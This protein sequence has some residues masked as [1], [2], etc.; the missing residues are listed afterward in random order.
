MIGTIE[1]SHWSCL[2]HGYSMTA[3]M[4]SIVDDDASAR[5]ATSRLVKS[6]GFAVATFASAEDFLQSDKIADTACLIV[7]ARMR[8]LSGIE[9]QS[10]LIARG[11]STPIIFIT[12]F[13]EDIRARALEA[14]AVGVLSKPYN[15]QSLIDCLDTALTIGKD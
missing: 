5:E 15:E 11:D 7:D 4:I 10:L 3:R 2:A 14:G 8:G 6:L 9:L 13:A 12:A 1:Q